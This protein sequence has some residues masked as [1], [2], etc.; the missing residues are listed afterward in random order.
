MAIV[1]IVVAVLGVGAFL[2]L[3]GDDDDSA[4]TA[5]EPSNAIPA[6]TESPE[7][8]GDDPA[9]DELAQRCFDG[10]MESCDELFRQADLDSAYETYGDT[11]AGRQEGEALPYCVDAFPQ[12]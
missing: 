4:T 11:C 3:R 9:F 2:V 1:A 12:D 10:S 5:T 8:L 7:G 6:A